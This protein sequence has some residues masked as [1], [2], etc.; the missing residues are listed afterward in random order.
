MVADLPW[1]RYDAV[2]SPNVIELPNGVLRMYYSGGDWYE[3]DAIGAAHSYDGGITWVKHGDPIFYPDPTSQHDNYKVTSPHVLFHDGW[4]YLFYCGFRGSDPPRV[5][6]TNQDIDHA[7][8]NLARSKYGLTNWEA[9]VEN[10]IVQ[11]E[12]RAGSWNCDAVYKPV[13]L[14][15]EAHSQWLLWYNG[16]CGHMEMIGM[17]TLKGGLGRF[18]RRSPHPGALWY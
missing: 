11:P 8:I 13:A 7:T 14:Y 12:Q 3:P 10:P 2:M 5:Q 6:L 18:V 17:S 16:R 4:F 9:S 1:E 15:D